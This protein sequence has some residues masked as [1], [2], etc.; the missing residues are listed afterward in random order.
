MDD[1]GKLKTLLCDGVGVKGSTVK[2]TTMQF[3]CSSGGVKVALD[4]K[5]L[6]T[7]S[8]GG[9][10]SDFCNVYLDDKAVSRSLRQSCLEN[11][12]KPYS[13]GKL[14]YFILLGDFLTIFQT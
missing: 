4:G 5:H 3:D 1:V 11:C 12:F 2:G 14:D 6:G 13:Y 10:A 8:S 9:F 7:V